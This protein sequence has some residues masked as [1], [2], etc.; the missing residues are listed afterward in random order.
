MKK[1][2]TKKPAQKRKPINTQ[3]VRNRL[4]AQFP[5]ADASDLAR[6]SRP[7]VKHFTSDGRGNVKEVDAPPKDSFFKT[8]KEGRIKPI[9]DRKKT[10]KLKDEVWNGNTLSNF[11]RVNIIVAPNMMQK[12]SIDVVTSEGKRRKM[13]AEDQCTM[14]V[15]HSDKEIM[16]SIN[17]TFHYLDIE[18]PEDGFL[19]EP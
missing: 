2:P 6:A 15:M 14:M 12:W 3:S 19:G 18:V 5:E 16:V 7:E 1:K 4:I 13:T 9:T 11:M 10:V 17:R 8:P